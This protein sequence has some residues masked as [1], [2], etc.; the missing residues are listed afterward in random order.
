MSWRGV[1]KDSLVLHSKKPD[2]WESGQML[3]KRNVVP[4]YYSA[5]TVAPMARPPAARATARGRLA[6]DVASASKTRA[7]MVRM[8]WFA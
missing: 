2:P 8:A 5:G 1:P 3:I 7:V 4:L 6:V